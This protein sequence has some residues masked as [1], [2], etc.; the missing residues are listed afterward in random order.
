M[1]ANFFMGDK[2]TFVIH[3]IC[4]A[5]EPEVGTNPGLANPTPMHFASEHWRKKK[6][7]NKPGETLKS[8]AKA[9]V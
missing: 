3:I 9:L 7:R 5:H 6:K 8:S 4:I 1:Q 2:C